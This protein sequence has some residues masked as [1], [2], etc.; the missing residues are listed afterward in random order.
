MKKNLFFICLTILILGCSEQKL[1]IENEKIIEEVD[2]NLPDNSPDT[3][4]NSQKN[5]KLLSLGD[6]YTIGESVCET[7]R[8]P[9]Q[10]KDS[11]KLKFNA[12]N[13]FSLKIIARTGWTTTN[14]LNAIKAENSENNYD[15]VTLLIGV[16]NQFQRRPF[17]IYQTE[18]INLV[19]TAILLAKG[20]KSNLIVVSI[21]DYAFTP[22]GVGNT[23][24]STDIDKY[25]DYAKN[26]CAATNITYVNITVITRMG[27]QNT[28]LVAS[29]R[30]HPS[31]LAYSKFVERILPIA[32][33]KLKD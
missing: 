6:S 18:F 12:D 25:N 29:D 9:E 22:F 13:T 24:I 28:E 10:L 2:Q 15:L 21:P 26:Y 30:L 17:N 8:F 33:Q 5:F 1:V 27:L 31:K 11:L 19:D 14:L 7:C 32:I 4:T 20:D 3:N 16:N 23:T